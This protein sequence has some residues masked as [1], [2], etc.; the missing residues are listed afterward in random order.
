MQVSGENLRFLYRC[1]SLTKDAG[2]VDGKNKVHYAHFKNRR[3]LILVNT[4]SH[5]L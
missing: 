1:I 3:F 4:K 2:G 5:V